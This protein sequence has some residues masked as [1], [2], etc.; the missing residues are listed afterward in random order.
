MEDIFDAAESKA[1]APTAS[2]SSTEKEETSTGTD[3]GA[4]EAAKD[5]KVEVPLHKDERF[6]RVIAERNQLR[7]EKA[8]WTKRMMERETESK[9]TSKPTTSESAPAWFQ[10][11]FGDDKEA[12]DGFKAMS[13]ADRDAL[14]REIRDEIENETK[15]RDSESKKWDSWVTEQ[16]QTLEEEGET[17]DKNALFKVMNEFRPTDDEGNLDFRKGLALLKRGSP[18]SQT[19][20]KRVAGAKATG[21]QKGTGEPGSKNFVTPADI[22]KMRLRGEL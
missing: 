5:L 19:A 16:V 3:G 20:E 11:Y 17:F 15:T 4:Q 12:W 22:R 10:K 14:K 21:T 6:K 7:Q 13:S 9:A 8:E 1:E 2:D 18:A